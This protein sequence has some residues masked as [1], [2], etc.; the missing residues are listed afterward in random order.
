MYILMADYTEQFLLMAKS[1]ELR[2]SYEIKLM[3]TDLLHCLDNEQKCPCMQSFILS[4][5]K[6]DSFNQKKRYDPP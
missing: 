3:L 6:M 5:L 4:W 2:K 1:K